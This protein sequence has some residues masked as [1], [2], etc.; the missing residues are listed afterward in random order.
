MISDLVT[1]VKHDILEVVHYIHKDVKGLVLHKDHLGRARATRDE[2]PYCDNDATG[3]LKG[4]YQIT[5]RN[6]TKFALDLAGA[7]Y[8]RTHE[9]VV[10]WLTYIKRSLFKIKY[11]VTFGTHYKKHAD[12]FADYKCITHLTVVM[13]QLVILNDLIKNSEYVV[14]F[15][16]KDAL[17]ETTS[18]FHDFKRNLILEACKRFQQHTEAIDNGDHEDFDIR[19][20]RFVA[21][22]NEDAKEI[23]LTSCK[24]MED[25]DWNNIRSGF[26]GPNDLEDFE[27]ENLKRL[28]QHRCVYKLPGDWRLVFL[29]H[30]LPSSAIPANCVSVN[31]FW[32]EH[33]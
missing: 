19:H 16:F 9:T 12:L 33:K 17:G 14:G 2:L 18:T 6:G 20:P 13:E 30:S 10:P 22:N 28:F 11:C 21:K 29:K 24:H 32:K 26:E 8:N 27:K 1:D 15:T 4:I 3:A 7:Q 23:F 5:L 31:P 25:F